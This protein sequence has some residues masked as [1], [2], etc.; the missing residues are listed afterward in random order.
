MK[1]R[2]IV[3]LLFSFF[4]IQVGAQ[5]KVF[6]KKYKPITKKLAKEYGIPQSVILS[7][8]GLESGWGR[9][10]HAKDFNNYFGIVGR[11][12]VSSNTRYRSFK[13]AEAGFRHFC[14]MIARKKY[15]ENLKGN[16]DSKAWVNVIAAHG[17]ST[18]PSVWK[19]RVKQVMNNL[20]L[21]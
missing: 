19:K 8:A 10:K 17:Y 21:K 2:I 6:I 16:K 1:L 14:E 9:S 13:S 20:H 5:K 3:F 11:N 15:Y 12:K 7:I 4:S 18:S